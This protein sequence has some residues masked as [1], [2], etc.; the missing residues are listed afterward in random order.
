MAKKKKKK[1]RIP[2]YGKPSAKGLVGG[3]GK[4]PEM[5]L[6]PKFKSLW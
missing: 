6:F 1:Y 4:V 3:G 2:T 5:S